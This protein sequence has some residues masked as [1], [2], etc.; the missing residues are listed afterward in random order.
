M[1]II[2]LGGIAALL[3]LFFAKKEKKNEPPIIGLGPE[4]PLKEF[5]VPTNPILFR[6]AVVAN[7]YSIVG[8]SATRYRDIFLEI[9]GPPTKGLRWDLDRPFRVWKNEQGEYQTEGVS[10][11]GL[12]GEGIQRRMGSLCAALRAPYDWRG[13]HAAISRMIQ[14]AHDMGAWVPGS[15]EPPLPGDYTVIGEGLSTHALTVV[16]VRGNTII[17]VDGGQVDPETGLQCVGLVSRPLNNGFI[18]S[19]KI[20]G[21]MSCVRGDYGPTMIAPVGWEKL[22]LG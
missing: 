19:R 8:V 4:T 1:G 16:A 7:C 2:G 3:G 22:V 21:H 20:Y 11:C 6:K 10:T 9:L 14:C 15:K 13:K 5:L 12:V 18:G 17:S